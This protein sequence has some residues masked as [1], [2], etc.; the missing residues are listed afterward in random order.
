V[1]G[2][3]DIGYSHCPFS[4]HQCSIPAPGATSGA[5]CAAFDIPGELQCI[6]FGVCD[7][8]AGG[9]WFPYCR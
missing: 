6:G 8:A 5:E 2:C 4:Q 1:C 7:G 9:I 3:Y